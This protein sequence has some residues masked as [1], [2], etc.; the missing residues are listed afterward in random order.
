MKT[1]ND[2]VLTSLCYIFLVSEC[3]V[4]NIF[5][6]IWAICDPKS[7]LANLAPP[8]KDDPILEHPLVHCLCRSWAYMLMLLGMFGIAGMTKSKGTA[9]TFLC[10]AAIGDLLHVGVYTSF[11]WYHDGV[12][13]LS[14]ASNYILSAGLFVLRLVWLQRVGVSTPKSKENIE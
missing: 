10:I 2:P 3:I 14:A 6:Q 9:S 13:S 12:W 7:F 8:Y 11:F 5:V 4:L 1:L